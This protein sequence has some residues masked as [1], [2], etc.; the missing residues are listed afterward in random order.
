MPQAQRLWAARLAV[1]RGLGDAGGRA[2]RAALLFPRAVLAWTAYALA[3]VT[4]W[5][6]R[7]RRSPSGA[8]CAR[9][10]RVIRARRWQHAARAAARRLV[11]A[12]RLRGFGVPVAAV[13]RRRVGV[14]AAGAA[15]LG[16][17]VG[18]GDDGAVRGVAGARAARRRRFVEHLPLAGAPARVRGVRGAGGVSGQPAGGVPAGRGRTARRASAGA[19]LA[20]AARPGARVVAP[21]TGRVAV[22]GA[23]GALAGE[24]A[25]RRR[26]AQAPP[27]RR[28]RGGSGRRAT[29]PRAQAAG[30]KTV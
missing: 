4:C 1:A 30:G 2:R 6:Q 21:R 16:L 22:A 7:P 17:G 23:G 9:S 24:G 28:R 20:A 26:R 15:P 11:A 5:R 10:R 25:G 18:R 12:V 3:A 19:R 8:R 14:A 27:A 29:A 13:H